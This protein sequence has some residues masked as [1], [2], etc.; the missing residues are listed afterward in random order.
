M[1]PGATNIPFIV[2]RKDYPTLR[3][4]EGDNPPT[5]RLREVRTAAIGRN[6]S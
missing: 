4:E 1:L 2:K 6:D 5:V 3:D